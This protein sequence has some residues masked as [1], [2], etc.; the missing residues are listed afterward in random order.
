M[1]GPPNLLLIMADQ[2]RHDWLGFGGARHVQTPALDALAARSLVFTQAT[3]SSPVCVPSRIGL[4]TGL[5][6]HRLGAL[7][8]HAYLPL[9]S[10]T[11]YQQLRD[12]G[13]HV[14]CCG[15]L[16]LA[17]PDPYNGLRGDRP[18]TYAWG[19][20]EPHECEGKIHAGRG[21]PPLGPYTA[22]LRE[23]GL[24]E[25]FVHDYADRARGGAAGILRPSVLPA[26]AIEDAYIG[27][28]AC[29]RIASLPA[30]FPWHYFVSFVGP[31]D[32]YDPPAELFERFAGAPMPPAI[33]FEPDHRPAR[34]RPHKQYAP[35][36]IPLARQ[37]YTASVQAIDLQVG[38]I[39]EALHERGEADNTWIIFCSDH[40]DMLG[41]HGRYT[42]SC[43]YESALRIPLMI[44]GPGLAPGTS[45]ALV[46]LI[47]LHPTLCELAGAAVPTGLDARSLVPL[48]LGQTDGHR[49]HATATLRGSHS[50]RTAEWKLIVDDCGASPELYRLKEDPNE[51]C[52]LADER[53]ETVGEL[54]RLLMADW[55]GT[56]HR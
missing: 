7:D 45:D 44:A 13:Y 39:L 55:V 41:D 27:Q 16:D 24:L 15:K 4:A 2:F 37:L 36:T 49:S 46:E 26:D 35:E 50:V 32:P 53:P 28:T 18:I 9:S 29:Q 5:R 21:N 12:H 43:H 42:K 10:R 38:R 52:N 11:C 25:A 19:F 51:R 34:Y 31:H 56:P 17:K 14:G 30:D 33:P 48:L 1:P 3:C 40:G 20:T 47:D 23:R 6:P 54:R 22:Y 8:N